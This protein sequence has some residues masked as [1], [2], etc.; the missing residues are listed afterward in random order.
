M[1][2]LDKLTYLAE[3]AEGLARWVPERERQDILRYYAE[4]FEEAGPER[5][6][7]VVQELGDPWALSCRLAVEGGFVTWEQANN[8]TPPKK[9]KWPWILL[10]TAAVLVFV[11]VSIASAAARI[12]R[13]VGQIVGEIPVE[14]T[15]VATVVEGDAV[16]PQYSGNV[17]YFE[18]SDKSGAGFWTMEDGYL[19][20]FVEIDVDASIANVTVTAGEDYT[21]FID[22]DATLGGYSLKWE[23]KNDVLRLRDGGA[24]GHVEINSWDDF[25][26]TFGINASAMDVTI[27]IPDGAQLKK[28]KAKIGLGDV[29]ISG[30][31]MEGKLEAETGLGD[32]ECYE[33]RAHD[34][35]DLESG[36]G[37]VTLSV[38]EPY[39]SAEFDVKTGMGT[40]ETQIDCLEK[41]WDYEAKTG[42]GNVTVNGDSRGAK[43]ERKGKGD[44][45][46]EL[47]SGMGDINLYFQ[48][49]RK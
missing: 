49:D 38:S 7:Q 5:E 42:M 11:V 22:S 48:D 10:G 26:N 23:V 31:E 45:K 43:V 13:F 15:G 41:D 37:D 17:A 16:E 4:Y 3:L 18:E 36:M 8:W 1:K 24:A 14:T 9:K 12:G 39:A 33:I 29:F 28:L 40:I 25:K 27:T 6:A 30:L 19:D 35:V 46:L 2:Q 21:L 34:E 32:V 47:E 20:P 44:Y